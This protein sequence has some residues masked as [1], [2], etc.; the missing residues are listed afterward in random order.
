[1]L[2]LELPPTEKAEEEEPKGGGANLGATAEVQRFLAEPLV[3][4]TS[5]AHLT[6]PEWPLGQAKI[7][8]GFI[9]Q[10]RCWLSCLTQIPL[11]LSST[12]EGPHYTFV[13]FPFSPPPPPLPL[14]DPSF[15]PQIIS[16]DLEA[17]VPSCP[18]SSHPPSLLSPPSSTSSSQRSPQIEGLWPLAC[19]LSQGPEVFEAKS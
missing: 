14:F 8:Q 9:A 10:G 4:T 11:Y 7:E 1:M 16:L 12:K 2:L 6:A 13:L 17:S 5:G 18:F 3:Q 15:P 19:L